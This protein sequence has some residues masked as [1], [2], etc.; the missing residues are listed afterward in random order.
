MKAHD[1]FTL[2][3]VMVALAVLAVALGALI[4]GAAD[5]TANS[6]YLQQKSFAT[7]VAA[8]KISEL[9]LKKKWLDKGKKSGTEEMAGYKWHWSSV[10]KATQSKEMRRLDVDVRL[11]AN[12]EN[13]L[14]KLASF[15]IDPSLNAKAPQAA[16]VPSAPTR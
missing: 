11:H 14:V 13:P 6:G 16:P 9:R 8:N 10:V 5:T 15:I 7:W 2:I 4:K 12:D 3:E 1:G